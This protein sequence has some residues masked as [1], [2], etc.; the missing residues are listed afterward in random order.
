M[1]QFFSPQRLGGN[2]GDRKRAC[3]PLRHGRSI[4]KIASWLAE[5]MKRLSVQWSLFTHA[6]FTYPSSIF[7]YGS[8]LKLVP[9]GDPAKA[10]Q[11]AEGSSGNSSTQQSPTTIKGIQ[12]PDILPAPLLR[13]KA[14]VL[15][16]VSPDKPVMFY[17]EFCT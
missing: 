1:A 17:L 8:L 7:S 3:L 9:R 2:M 14:N 6:C 12:R 13:R 15:G 5:P 16:K 4:K 11:V 10:P